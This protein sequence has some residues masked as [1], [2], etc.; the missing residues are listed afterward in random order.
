MKNL[1]NQKNEMKARRIFVSSRSFVFF[2]GAVLLFFPTRFFAENLPPQRALAEAAQAIED[3]VPQVAQTTLEALLARENLSPSDRAVA[4][5]QLARAFIDAG[6]ADKALD[7]LSEQNAN[8]PDDQWLKMQALM[9]LERWAEA[10][11][12]C[13][14]LSQKND[15]PFS[16]AAALAEAEA[17]RAL[18]KKGDAIDV[19]QN[20]TQRKTNVV[21]AKL[22]LADLFLETGGFKKVPPLLASITPA[23]A[24]ET[25]WKKYDEAQLLLTQDQAAPAMEI[26][27][28]ILKNPAGLTE[29]LFAGATVGVAEAR[30][31]LNGREV[32]DNVIEDFI[33]Q[34]PESA[35]LEEMFARLDDIYA[36]EENPSESELQR[37]MQRPPERR[38]ALAQ[39]YCAKAEVRE[40]KNEKAARTLNDFLRLY[41]NHPLV[42]EAWRLLGKVRMDTAKIASAL[43]AFEAALRVCADEECRARAELDLGVAYF[44]R[45]DYLLAASIFEDAMRRT[46]RGSDALRSLWQP[47]AYDCALAWLN[48]GNYAKFLDQYG[49]ISEHFPESDV[50]RELLLEEGLLQA[51]SRDFRRATTTLQLFIRDFPDHPRVPEAKLALAEIAFSS[52]AID[53]ARV[54]LKA[55]YESP[56][57]VETASED[58]IKQTKERADYLA[59]FIADSA[60]ARGEPGNGDGGKVV[61]LCQ[62]FL[63]E[64][65]DSALKAEV[66]MKLGEAFFRREDF[67]NAQT[68]FET[69]AEEA[70][71]NPLAEK[72]LF[73]AGQSAM[74]S[75][76]TDRAL[77]LFERVVKL[78]GP[79]KLYARQEQAVAKVQAGKENEAVVLYDDILRSQPENGLRFAALCGKADSL[80]SLAGADPQKLG[81]AIAIYDQLADDAE[82]PRFWKDQ[83]L[84]KK[85]TCLEK[86]SHSDDALAAFYEALQPQSA[87]DPEFFWFYKAGFD[88]A[89]M[90]EAQTQWKSA[91]GIYEKMAKTEGPRS[92]EAKKRAEQLRLEHF[93]WD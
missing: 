58:E 38:A 30:I 19:L 89:R 28:G 7:L 73:L 68:Q 55:A 52:S 70:P 35:Y 64:H 59:I 63:R 41:P 23:N 16:D 42:G 85:G 32:A 47:A 77:E 22:R 69:L 27:E 37:W 5:R 72:A 24:L 46:S 6:H 79:L 3:H 4:T 53:R 57:S 75:M 14:E 45:R 56:T 10:L 31:I 17:L 62:K 90:L 8:E 80:A 25:Q 40:K 48:L 20:L 26:F 82:V 54:F 92:D 13:R 18:G 87:N 49:T 2:C 33:W 43:S 76:N 1:T 83:A 44:S 60:K 50:R 66:R 67:A 84:Y 78:G 15:S 34:H 91:V 9:A 21:L 11:P 29:S 36:G 51:R 86:L 12:I 61:D 93:I 81:E 65:P 71:G 74:R 39:F 88:A